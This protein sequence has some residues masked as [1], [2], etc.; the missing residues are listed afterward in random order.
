MGRR[1]PM[2][3]KRLVAHIERIFSLITFNE[4]KYVTASEVAQRLQIARGTCKSNIIPLLTACYLPGRKH[5]LYKQ[6]E[7]EQLSQVRTIEKQVQPLTLVQQDYEVVHIGES[8]C[9]EAL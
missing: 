8:L 2:G 6:S 1:E 9:R 3:L 4:E 5:A 7:V